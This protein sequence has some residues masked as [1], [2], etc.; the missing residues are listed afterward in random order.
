MFLSNLK[1]IFIT[2]T[3]AKTDGN[4]NVVNKARMA[5]TANKSNTEGRNSRML[6]TG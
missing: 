3:F 2:G 4:E 6:P 5:T 1:I